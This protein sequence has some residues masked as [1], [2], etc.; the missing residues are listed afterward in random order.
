MINDTASRGYQTQRNPQRSPGIV[1]HSTGV[2][3]YSP[4]LVLSP[5]RSPAPASHKT[6]RSE[7]HRDHARQA[8]QKP[9]G[10][11]SVRNRSTATLRRHRTRR[12]CRRRRRLSLPGGREGRRAGCCDIRCAGDGDGSRGGQAACC[13]RGL[14]REGRGAVAGRLQSAP[15]A[16]RDSAEERDL[17]LG[18][19]AVLRVLLLHAELAGRAGA[20][21]VA[22]QHLR[23]HGAHA[24]PVVG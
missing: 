7:K 22:R 17:H 4:L 13:R 8:A 10:S 5:T 18:R 14:G 20:V 11:R 19:L 12:A 2:Y 16:R 6:S 21:V 1:H 9:N 3:V 15:L 23:R 24:V